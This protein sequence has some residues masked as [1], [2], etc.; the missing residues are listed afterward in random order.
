MPPWQDASSADLLIS[1]VRFQVV[2]NPHIAEH[3]SL[4]ENHLDDG[5]CAASESCPALG[6]IDPAQILT[7][8]IAV[9]PDTHLLTLQRKYQ[10]LM[11][12]IYQFKQPGRLNPDELAFRLVRSRRVDGAGL[13]EIPVDPR[14]AS[15]SWFPAYSW[16][17]L[18]CRSCDGWRHLGWRFTPKSA[19]PGLVAFDALIVEYAEG[20]RGR[21][22]EAARDA[23][24]E[25]LTVGVRA[26]AWMIA[27]ATA[28]VGYQAS[29]PK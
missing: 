27:L 5:T 28:T 8:P 21:A 16:S 20:Q 22:A 19:D 13:I 1:R 23:V 6:F 29:S 18:V 11:V 25:E 7:D 9:Q 10:G 26:P 14:S 12:P 17:I 2:E 15:D 24:L 3:R 4:E